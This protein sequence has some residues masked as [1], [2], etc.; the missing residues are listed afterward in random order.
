MWSTVERHGVVRGH[1]VVAQ[2]CYWRDWVGYWRDWGG[3]C[4]VPRHPHAPARREGPAHPARQVP[5]RTRRGCGDHERPG[6]LPLRLPAG[7]VRPDDRGHEHHAGHSQRSPGLQP[8][9]VRQRLR[10]DPG[11]AGPCYRPAL[12]ADLRRP[13]AGL[14]RDRRQHPHGD[15]G[16]RCLGDLPGQPGG[17]L[18][19]SV[20]G[21][22]ARDLVTGTGPGARSC[23][24]RRGLHPRWAVGWLAS[25][26]RCQA[27][28]GPRG[29]DGVPA[30]GR[31]RRRQARTLGV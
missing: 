10:R 12:A 29:A 11:Q 6:A 5:R 3:E 26:P 31:R 22:A 20:A 8:R 25:L 28:G 7:G 27:A 13:G 15:L 4:R 14:R 9:A 19:G 21:G 2:L 16:R 23:G 1:A 30:G 17:S 24:P 18:L